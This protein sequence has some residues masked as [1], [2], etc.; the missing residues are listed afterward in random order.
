MNHLRQHGLF[1]F[2]VM[3]GI[4]NLCAPPLYRHRLYEDRTHDWG[5]QSFQQSFLLR[6]REARLDLSCFHRIGLSAHTCPGS[7]SDNGAEL[8]VMSA[9][10]SGCLGHC[11]SPL[12]HRRQLDPFMH[13]LPTRPWQ[14]ISLTWKSL[15]FG[16]SARAISA[17]F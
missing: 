17:A 15:R 13:R 5:G 9:R 3:A 8:F 1:V 16:M 4:C 6:R 11:E 10:C 14:V 7:T 12:E 2:D